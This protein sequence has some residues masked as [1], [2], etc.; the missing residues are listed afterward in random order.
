[1][2]NTTVLL[3]ATLVGCSTPQ[4]QPEPQPSPT[5]AVGAS[6]EPAAAS[7][8]TAPAIPPGVLGSDPG[9]REALAAEILRGLVPKP[10]RL[11]L[12]YDLGSV[13][14]L[15]ITSASEVMVT[16]LQISAEALRAGFTVTDEPSTRH[17]F[18]AIGYDSVH[19]REV[20]SA[21]TSA[22]FDWLR[23]DL[24]AGGLERGGGEVEWVPCGDRQLLVSTERLG[25]AA[26]T[27]TSRSQ[28]TPR[29]SAA[30]TIS[31]LLA[32]RCQAADG[33]D[34]VE[35]GGGSGDFNVR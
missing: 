16:E 29:D 35:V 4:P 1:M 9:R 34:E 18:E 28:P 24:V 30:R 6:A 5:P 7:Q 3:A 14:Q 27:G 23:E 17:P 13:R 32:Q 26:A 21:H 15:Q 22:R 10:W 11:Q 31:R 33:A 19:V 2:R 20:S 8:T 12:V 25:S